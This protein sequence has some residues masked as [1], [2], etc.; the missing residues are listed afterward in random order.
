MSQID[1]SI[2]LCTY[3][4]A[5][6]LRLAL[7]SLLRLDTHGAFTY[8]IVLVDNQSTDHTR[9]VVEELSASADVPVNYIVETR[10]GHVYAWNRGVAEARGEWI[11][12]FDDDQIADPDWV[13]EL[14]AAAREKNC[15]S[16][17]GSLRLKLPEGCSRRL[18]SQ[19]RLVL[20]ESFAWGEMRPYTRRQG[21][22]SGNQLLHRS[23]LEHVGVFD[24]DYGVRG[25]DTDLYR[26]IRQAGYESWFAP[27]A[28]G[29]HITPASRLDDDYLLLTARRNG[30]SFSLRDRREW[31]IARCLCVAALRV[32]HSTLKWGPRWL[33]ARARGDHEEALGAKCGIWQTT[34]YVEGCL[35]RTDIEARPTVHQRVAHTSH[36]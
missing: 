34:G 1:V 21:P 33:V 36:A 12:C 8:E 19:T 6:M 4:R 13:H 11:A 28:S 15:L 2:V 7:D 29:Q 24:P 26:R 30:L 10:Q 16:V 27:R 9:S 31:G 25:Y 32:A 17:G 3:N 35:G 18:A 5:D 14:L 20:G 23:V 22:G